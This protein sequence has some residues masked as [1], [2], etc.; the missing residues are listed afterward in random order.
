MSDDFSMEELLPI[1]AKL[2]EKYTSGESSSVTYE[3]AQGLMQAVLYCINE[4]R[5]EENVLYAAEMS[6]KEVYQI[7]YQMVVEKAK[8]TTAVST[9]VPCGVCVPH[10]GK[11]PCRLQKAVL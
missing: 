3:R 1:V 2:A 8:E 9:K 5:Q 10:I 4:T 6:A 7:G 11:A